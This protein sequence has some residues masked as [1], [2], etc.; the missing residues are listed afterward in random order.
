MN[1]QLVE[2]PTAAGHYWAEDLN[3]DESIVEV[4]P[5]PNGF[6]VF[7]WPASRHAKPVEMFRKFY[8]PVTSP[9]LLADSLRR[10]QLIAAAA[11]RSLQREEARS[12]DEVN[13]SAD[14]LR[15]VLPSSKPH[16]RS[17]EYAGELGRINWDFADCSN[18]FVWLNGA[19]Y[20]WQ[21]AT[22]GDFRGLCRAIRVS[23]IDDV[24]PAAA[25]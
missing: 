8:G 5:T 15:A 21:I 14:W 18:L 16:G 12:D 17:A 25:E 20:R 6:V 4:R 10:G 3:G 22:R 2:R 23:L 1:T 11:R 24:A 19:V 13:L 9:E 7:D